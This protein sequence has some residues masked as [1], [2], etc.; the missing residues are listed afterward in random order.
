[1]L[2]A[3]FHIALAHHFNWDILDSSYTVYISE[4]YIRHIRGMGMM[5]YYT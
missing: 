3:L 2:K 4:L 5:N 1:M